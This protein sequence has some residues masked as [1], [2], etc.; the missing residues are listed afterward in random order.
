MRKLI[1]I[2]VCTIIL[3]SPVFTY[4]GDEITITS[5]EIVEKLAKLEALF[6]GFEKRLDEMDK[7]LDNM[8]I[9]LD[10]RFDDAKWVLGVIFT[11]LFSIVFVIL[12]YIILEIMRLKQDVAALKQDVAGIKDGIED[13]RK[14]ILSGYSMEERL[15]KTMEDRIEKTVEERVE[16]IIESRNN[17]VQLAA[18]EEI[19]IVKKDQIRLNEKIDQILQ[20]LKLP[21]L[22]PSMQMA[23]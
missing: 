22:N 13:L 11:F 17:H 2:I 7:R 10:K 12:G 3:L 14:M 20:Y 8:E 16:K 1:A 9:R 23:S 21:E 18:Q 19:R 15:E 5:R 6:Y 4:A